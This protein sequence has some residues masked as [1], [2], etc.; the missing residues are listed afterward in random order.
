MAKD[1]ADRYQTVNELLED[2]RQISGSGHPDL[3][4]SR[5]ITTGV[6]REAVMRI[7]KPTQPEHEPPTRDV[8]GAAATMA[9][10]HGTEIEHVQSIE[11]EEEKRRSPA[12]FVF[13]ALLALIIGGGAAV[14]FIPELQNM[15]FGPQG[16]PWIPT[17]TPTPTLTPTPTTTPTV[18]PTATVTP[19]PSPIPTQAPIKI[20]LVVDPPAVVLIDGKPLASG[21]TAG[22]FANLMPGSH[23]FTLTIPDYPRQ[24]ITREITA[25]TKTISLI[26]DVGLL[27]VTVDR[28]N[29]P[30]G[31]V[32]FLD[33]E[34]LGPVPLVRAKVPAGDHELVVR[35]P[36]LQ[37]PY[38]RRINVPRMP[39]QLVVPPVAPPSD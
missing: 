12:L 33:G 5:E 32:A 30:P 38:R 10:P 36:E 16:A 26:I 27:T 35:W 37:T 22:G 29:A 4:T 6:I 11:E 21:A 13:L 20:R 17:P 1:P 31:G 25:G 28:A 2:L 19:T 7:E 3:E 8:S 18:S 39:N 15:I 34:R 24:T 14:Y 9:T 23:T